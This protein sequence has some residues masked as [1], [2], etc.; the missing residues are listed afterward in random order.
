VHNTV[1]SYESMCFKKFGGGP[2]PAVTGRRKDQP[3]SAKRHVSRSSCCWTTSPYHTSPS[4]L[5]HLHILT[6]LPPCDRYSG[7]PWRS[8]LLALRTATLIHLLSSC[9]Q[10]Q[11]RPQEVHLHEHQLTLSRLL[12]SPSKLSTGSAITAEISSTLSTCPSDYYILVSQP[13]VSTADYASKDTTPALASRLSPKPQRAI[14]SSVSV[15]DVAGPVDTVEISRNIASVCGAQVVDINTA[16]IDTKALKPAPRILRVAFAPAKSRS[17]LT[18]ADIF[19]AS[20]LDMLPSSNYTVLYTT[21]TVSVF[22]EPATEYSMD[23]EIQDALHMDLKRDLSAGIERRANNVTLIDGPLFH[24][25]QFL[26]PGTFP[27]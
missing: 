17:A 13:G 15:P 25:Y 20:L 27:R 7:A 23:S 18:E 8:L 19:L 4:T 10:P 9:S 11:S 14:L 21:T 16:S 1:E 22:A 24:R 26:T 3:G 2:D 5:S 6:Q 12:A